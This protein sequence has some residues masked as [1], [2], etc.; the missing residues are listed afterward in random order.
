MVT[1]SHHGP[2]QPDFRTIAPF[3]G[4]GIDVLALLT[5]MSQQMLFQSGQT[6][7]IADEKPPFVGFVLSGI[8]RMEKVLAD[9]NRHIVGLLVSGDMFGRVFDGPMPYGVEAATGSRIILF[10][11]GPFEDLVRQSAE[12]DRLVIHEILNEIDRAR[13]WMIILGYTRVQTR[14]CGFLVLL[15]TRYRVVADVVLERD[16]S[17]TVHLP[18]TRQDMAY[19][20]GTRTESI[21]RALHALQ[22]LGYI[23]IIHSDLIS[24]VN[25]A[26]LTDEIGEEYPTGASGFPQPRHWKNRAGK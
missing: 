22:D 25:L 2:A 23:R 17:L 10:R 8:L 15:C 13:D 26:S 6:V 19:L 4:L 14:I 24:I 20:L 9:G 3:S 21:S 1:Y 5:S 12:L 18:I 16:D 7:T 11:R